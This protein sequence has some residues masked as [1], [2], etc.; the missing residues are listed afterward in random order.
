MLRPDVDRDERAQTV[1]VRPLSTSSLWVVKVLLGSFR[2]VK[3]SE[4]ARVQA[5]MSDVACSSYNP[6][7]ILCN[8]SFADALDGLLGEALAREVASSSRARS[9]RLDDAPGSHDLRLQG[10]QSSLGVLGTD[11]AH[12]EVVANEEVAGA[13]PREQFGPPLREPC[14]VDGAR[15][16]QTIDGFLARRSIDVS[17]EPFRQLTLRKVPVRQQA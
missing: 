3:R 10:P 14:I 15:G 4:T 6:G 12:L 9:A 8:G 11:S 2:L 13:A 7:G 17:L 1:P 5:K 16:D